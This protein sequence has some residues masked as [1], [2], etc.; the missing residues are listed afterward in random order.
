M[1]RLRRAAPRCWCGP[2]PPAAPISCAWRSSRPPAAR[3]ATITS[4]PARWRTER[5]RGANIAP[6]EGDY[7]GLYAGPALALG[8]GDARAGEADVNVWSTTVGLA[9][10]L[11]CASD[12][13]VHAG[14][15]LSVGVP[16]T[17]SNPIYPNTYDYTVTV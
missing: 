3:P 14:T 1:T 7:L 6:N 17:N 4:S 11:G 2:R 13:T 9:Y 15:T 8:W 5:S 12:T 10:T 16:L